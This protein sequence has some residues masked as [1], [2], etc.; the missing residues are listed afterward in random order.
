MSQD[1]KIRQSPSS[2]GKPDRARSHDPAVGVFSVEHALRMLHGLETLVFSC[3]STDKDRK[4]LADE[5]LRVRE[6][7]LAVTPAERPTA[8][9]MQVLTVSHYTS[10]LKEMGRNAPSEKGVALVFDKSVGSRGKDFSE[11]T[12]WVVF[13]PWPGSPTPRPRPGAVPS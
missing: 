12:A 5:L 3:N 8:A 11:K 1:S 4:T 10:L 6:R 13:D 7:L 9:G 2:P